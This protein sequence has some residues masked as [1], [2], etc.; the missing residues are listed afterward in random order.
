MVK[1]CDCDN[2]P[3][4]ASQRTRLES[5]K[6][7]G[8]VGDNHFHDFIREAGGRFAYGTRP[9]GRIPE[10]AIDLDF[11]FMPNGNRASREVYPYETNETEVRTIHVSQ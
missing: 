6:V 5:V 10:E 3:G 4:T 9:R 2:V 8:E 7:V 11:A 1:M